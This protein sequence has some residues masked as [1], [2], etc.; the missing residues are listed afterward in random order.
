MIFL[1]IVGWILFIIFCLFMLLF[2][3]V[4]IQDYGPKG[5]RSNIYDKMWFSFEMC[6]I[7]GKKN[8]GEITETQEYIELEKEYL[9]NKQRIDLY[10]LIHQNALNYAYTKWNSDYSALKTQDENQM[11]LAIIGYWNEDF[12]TFSL[13]KIEEGVRPSLMAVFYD[14]YIRRFF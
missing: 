2:I 7:A 10:A 11:P 9:A 1:K 8:R 12:I 6:A 4:L 13:K 5:K 14:K 3:I